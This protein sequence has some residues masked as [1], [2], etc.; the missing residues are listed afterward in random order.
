MCRL[1]R[2]LQC[3]AAPATSRSGWLPHQPPSPRCKRK[4][5][6]WWLPQLQALNL[7]QT[8]GGSK[9]TE[10]A[11]RKCHL[12][13]SSCCIDSVQGRA[14]DKDAVQLSKVPQ[15]PCV[16]FLAFVYPVPSLG[17]AAENPSEEPW[18]SEVR[19]F[20][21]GDVLSYARSLLWLMLRGHFQ[22]SW[23][24]RSLSAASTSTYPHPDGSLQIPRARTI[25]P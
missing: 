7:L 6:T 9:S 5:T 24:K 18:I 13:L 19:L 25:L 12:Q 14:S 4:A 16:P 2:K 20:R 1:F 11:E 23:L 22:K 10:A 15:T 17:F 3:R 8:R 21:V